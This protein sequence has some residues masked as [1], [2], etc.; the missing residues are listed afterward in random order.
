MPIPDAATGGGVVAGVIALLYSLRFFWPKQKETSEQARDMKTL[1]AYFAE[2]RDDKI[3]DMIRD[4]R[5]CQVDHH[6]IVTG[7][8]GEQTR[9]LRG[10]R[11]IVIRIALARGLSIPTEGDQV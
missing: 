8:L 1:Q 2:V 10:V 11:D 5:Q 3:M 4:L 9:L 7:M 6:A